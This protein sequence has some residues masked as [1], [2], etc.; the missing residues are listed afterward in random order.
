M[1]VAVTRNGDIELAYETVGPVGERPL[2]L[3]Q[4][5]GAPML[6]WPDG[7]CLAL[8]ERGFHVARFDNRDAGRSSRASAP[9][10]LA[11]MAADG[12]AVLDA[13]AWPAAHLVGVSLGGMVAQVMAARQPARVLSLTSMSSAP[14]HRVRWDRAKIRTLVRYLAVS[15]RKPRDA[16]AAGDQLLEVFRIVG[17]PGHPPDEEWVRDVARRAFP[18]RTDFA[19]ARRQAAAVR[20]TG[21][22][23]TELARITAPTLVLTGEDDP[24]QPVRAGRATAEAI[25]GARFVAIPGMGHDLPRALWPTLADHIDAVAGAR[26]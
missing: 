11:D 10:S 16:D 23:R 26:R 14:D 17:S 1:T 15:R 13:L 24:V 4:G 3:I 6:G 9:Y 5:A 7:F 12:T 18:D 19:A 2:L 20:S 22:R 25:P 21:D 8:A